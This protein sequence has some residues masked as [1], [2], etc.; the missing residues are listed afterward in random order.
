MAARGL[1]VREICETL[2]LP[3]AEVELMLKLRNGL[4]TRTPA[5][6]RGFGAEFHAARG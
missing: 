2:C 5:T 3:K 4:S 6:A 1:S